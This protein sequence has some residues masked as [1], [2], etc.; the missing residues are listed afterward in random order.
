MQ[1]L[2]RKIEIAYDRITETKL[3]MYLSG[4]ITKTPEFLYNTYK[5]C[6][7]S[8]VFSNVYLGEMYC[9]DDLPHYSCIVS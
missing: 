4:I 1:N 8:S 3:I 9:V 7:A 6:D 5:T 2:I